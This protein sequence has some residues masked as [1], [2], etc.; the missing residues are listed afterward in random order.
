MQRYLS[1]L[2]RICLGAVLVVFFLSLA[3][4]KPGPAVSAAP[5]AIGESSYAVHFLPSNFPRLCVG[6]SHSY[7]FMV[8]FIEPEEYEPVEYDENGL[9]LPVPLIGYTARV[10]ATNGTVSPAEFNMGSPYHVFRFDYTAQSEGTEVLQVTIEGGASGSATK[11]LQIA[12][13]C[14]YDLRFFARE[15]YTEEGAGYEAVF[16]GRGYFFLNR[17]IAR[18]AKLVG[19]G[20]HNVSLGIWAEAPEVFTCSMVPLRTGGSFII[21]GELHSAYDFMSVNLD[22]ESVPLPDSMR[23]DCQALGLGT[24]TFNFPIGQQTADGKSLNMKG[25][26]FPLSGGVETITLGSV[27]F[28]VYVKQK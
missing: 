1:L 15:R 3:S 28:T 11:T 17:T 7:A 6:D 14:R 4:F 23:F 19:D 27:Q 9:P 21:D 8:K 22:F 24:V 13:S 16:K 20:S 26:T 5:E 12:G 10:S 2:V 18:S 25:L